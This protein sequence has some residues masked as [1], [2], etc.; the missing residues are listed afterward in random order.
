MLLQSHLTEG[1]GE[2]GEVRNID[3]L[4]ALPKAWPTGS[5]KGLCARGGFEVDMEWK[6]GALTR[7]TIRSKLGNP[8][9]VRGAGREVELQTKR[10]GEVCFNGDLALQTK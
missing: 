8:C 3:L 4:P 1:R 6:D 5:V 10:G 9:K 2:K 7:A